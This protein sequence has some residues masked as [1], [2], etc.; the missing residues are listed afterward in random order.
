MRPK[1]AA[2]PPSHVYVEWNNLDRGKDSSKRYTAPAEER[3]LREL[4]SEVAMELP[5][6]A[7]KL[8]V[9]PSPPGSHNSRLLDEG[10]TRRAKTTAGG[11]K[12]RLL[13]YRT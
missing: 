3:E 5:G 13:G 2:D 8:P 4:G 10:H 11:R 6:R 1:D 9:A 12:G 7:R